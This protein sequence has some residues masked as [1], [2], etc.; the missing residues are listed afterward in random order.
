MKN[1]KT[2]Q[3]EIINIP[4]RQGDI[5]AIKIKEL[6]KGLKKKGTNVLVHSDS[7]QHDHTLVKGIVYVD[8]EGKMFADVPFETQIVHTADHKPINISAG[9]YEIR[10][11]VQYSMGDMVEVVI[12]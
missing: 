6:P 5:L 3:L 9:K 2:K 7:T 1:M 10:R 12:D 4:G 8:R 11:Q